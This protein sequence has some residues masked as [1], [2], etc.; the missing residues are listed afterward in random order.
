MIDVDELKLTNDTL[1]HAEGDEVLRAT[2]RIL[3]QAFRTNDLVARIGGDEFVVLLPY[4]T[5]PVV[6]KAVIRIRKFLEK[7]NQAGKRTNVLL[8]IG[9]A[10]TEVGISLTEAIK[11]ADQNMYESKMQ[12]R[13]K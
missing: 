8:S 3:Q 9:T 11:L 10:C 7:N 1:G 6:D 2:S 13:K 5:G 4:S 12:F